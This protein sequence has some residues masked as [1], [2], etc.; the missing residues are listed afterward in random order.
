MSRYLFLRLLWVLPITLGFVTGVFFLIHLLPGD[1]VDLLL[2][3]MAAVL[4]R[5]ALRSA[6][7]LDEPILKQYGHFLALLFQ[8]DL[9]QSFSM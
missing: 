5:S 8:G 7:H 6:L 3:E 2:G 9:G 4:A 1:P